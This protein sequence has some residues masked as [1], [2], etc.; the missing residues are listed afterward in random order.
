MVQGFGGYNLYC[1]DAS[2]KTQP[3]ESITGHFIYRCLTVLE[4]TQWEDLKGHNIRV[5]TSNDYVYAI[6]HYLKDQ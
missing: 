3:V 6:G 4:L 5:K 2:N 1:P